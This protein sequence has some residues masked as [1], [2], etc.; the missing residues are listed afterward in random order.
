MAKPCEAG[1]CASL[2]PPE[3]GPYAHRVNRGK[4]ALTAARFAGGM[5]FDRYV[6]YTG[7]SENLA[8]EAGWWLGRTRHDFSGLLRER[9]E[10]SRLDGARTAAIRW[11]AA[12]TNGPGNWP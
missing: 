12:Q 1:N 11:L 3:H 5:T 6:V 7:S 8:R 9:Y 2:D 10:R 4:G